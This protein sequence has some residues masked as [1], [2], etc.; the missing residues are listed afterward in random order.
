MFLKVSTSRLFVPIVLVISVF[1]TARQNIFE[2]KYHFYLLY[3][4]EW[5]ESSQKEQ[6]SKTYKSNK[7]DFRT[8]RADVC[9]Q[10][11]AWGLDMKGM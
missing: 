10:K 6:F 7:A 11:Q 9:S 3:T 2:T 5:G 8:E 1:L 4:T